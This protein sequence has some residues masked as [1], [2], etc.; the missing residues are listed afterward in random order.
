MYI[1]QLFWEIIYQYVT[2]LVIISFNPIIQLLEIFL[3]EII[4]DKFSD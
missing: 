4:T 2:L 3:K 1:G